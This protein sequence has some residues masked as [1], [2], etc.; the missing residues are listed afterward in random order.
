MHTQD[1]PPTQSFG[2]VNLEQHF[3]T[4]I[5][6]KVM[7]H[8]HQCSSVQ[9]CYRPSSARSLRKKGI[10]INLTQNCKW[11]EH[12]AITAY[13]H[14]QPHGSDSRELS[15]MH[16]F[17]EKEKTMDWI[18]LKVRGAWLSHLLHLAQKWDRQQGKEEPWAFPF[19]LHLCLLHPG[20]Q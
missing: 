7:S 9:S 13:P 11:F 17:L 4:A 8:M 15:W 20:L 3:P 19:T 5:F 18:S 14:P 1:H 6:G 10:L 16:K 2:A 12:I